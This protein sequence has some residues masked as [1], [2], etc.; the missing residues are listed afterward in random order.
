[1]IE[2]IIS[3]GQIGADIAGLR[4]GKAL[5]LKT[6]GW[7]PLGFR[8]LTGDK[9]EY[10]DEYGMWEHSEHGY[11]PRTYLNVLE[12]DG[13]VRFAY[14]FDSPGERCTLKAINSYSKPS[15]D[16]LIHRHEKH[17]DML[18]NPVQFAM[19]LHEM[20]IKV[21]NI[22]GN[23]NEDIEDLVGVYLSTAL[24]VLRSYE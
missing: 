13:T 16:V 12:S 20:K 22:S 1:M 7:M 24:G 15:F 9:P 3:G 18:P 4:V 11:S 6:G 19:W 17:A 8:T 5:G 23:A 14:D 10:G 2:K 21:L